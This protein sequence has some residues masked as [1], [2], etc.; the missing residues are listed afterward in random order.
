MGAE[1]A[2]KDVPVE[3][4][5]K[6]QAFATYR[7]KFSDMV[8]RRPVGEVTDKAAAVEV[9]K[10]TK[11]LI[12]E[13]SKDTDSIGQRWAQFAR[14]T[15]SAGL[16]NEEMERE[17]LKQFTDENANESL[18]RVAAAEMLRDAIFKLQPGGVDR[19][20]VALRMYVEKYAELCTIDR[21]PSKE[22]LNR[23][24][25]SLNMTK[26]HLEILVEQLG[27]FAQRASAVEQ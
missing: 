17:G 22:A 23:V 25:F 26:T 6:D 27:A 2:K 11:R 12:T 8:S 9:V 13:T 5:G 16:A 21:T 14:R 20:Y 4:A 15:G 3:E 10:A 18:K 1:P 19:L 24:A 7:A